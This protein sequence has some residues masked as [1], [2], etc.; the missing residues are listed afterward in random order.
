[1]LVFA[2]DIGGGNSFF[3]AGMAGKVQA[4]G[5]LSPKKLS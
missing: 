4:P 3:P 1:M 5:D 2:T